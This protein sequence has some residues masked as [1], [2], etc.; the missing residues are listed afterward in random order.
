M[1]PCLRRS[2]CRWSIFLPTILQSLIKKKRQKTVSKRALMLPVNR[3]SSRVR[4]AASYAHRKIAWHFFVSFPLSAS[5]FA[6]RL[7]FFFSRGPRVK[8]RV[9]ERPLPA[10]WSA[11]CLV[12]IIITL[13][14]FFPRCNAA[15]FIHRCDRVLPHRYYLRV[16]GVG[17][18]GQLTE[19]R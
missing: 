18:R 19:P 7:F 8:A 17:L 4:R 2:A 5:S 14:D 11:R 13:I 6:T 3:Q 10:V 9:N 15:P 12:P 16:R 1:G